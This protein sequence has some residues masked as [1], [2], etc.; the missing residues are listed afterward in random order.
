VPFSIFRST[1]VTSQ[2]R[3]Q[4]RRAVSILRICL[5]LLSSVQISATAA[6]K[7]SPFGDLGAA[8]NPSGLNT[9]DR[10]AILNLVHAYSH[11]ADGLHTERFGEFFTTDAVFEIVP[12]STK[13]KNVRQR[14]GKGRAEIVAALA[15]RHMEFE[16]DGIQRRHFLTNPVV[17]DQTEKQARVA[18]YLQ[19]RSSRRGGPSELVATGRYEG[20][21]RKTL[22]GW[23]MA[24]W[25]IHSDQEI[26]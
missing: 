20:L 7:V 14:V 13:G 26:K 12:Y 4:S 10:V 5:I 9:E 1:A 8:L 19:L 11:F 17:W 3:F 16:R 21:A 22:E 24:I 15:P 25:T 18:V 6:S 2:P 23:R